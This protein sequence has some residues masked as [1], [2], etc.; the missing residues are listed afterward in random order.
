M[1][2]NRRLPHP[3]VLT[4]KLLI[5]FALLTTFGLIS[6]AGS[7]FAQGVGDLAVAP[8]RVVLE[9]RDRSAQIS[10]LNRGTVTATYR[11]SI[12]NMQMTE[13]GEYVRVETS[14]IDEGHADKLIRYAPR[15]V[16]LEP[17]K[18][19]TVRVLLRKPP[20]LPDGE[21]RSHI[22]FQ[23]VPSPDAG[24]SVEMATNN[25]GL[26]IRLIVVPGITIPLIVRQGNL[27]ANAS[28]AIG[29][30]STANGA[31]GGP[32]LSLQISRTGT[33]SL[34]GDIAAIYTAKNGKEYVVG[35]INQLA[36]YTP[37]RSRTINL[38][39]RIP[40]AVKLDGGQIRVE[41]RARPE[42][43]GETLASARIDVP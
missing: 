18:S 7:A 41:Y 15:Q 25:E 24:R 23:A 5:A 4:P 38:N 42:D 3:F 14:G 30:L 12:V 31:K 36:V 33:R 26:S 11:V 40:D 29:R 27:A 37:N 22:L 17:G 6:G 21:Y 35:E 20:N 2:M 9:G 13:A 34:F 1:R 43:G 8:T 39:L 28:L 16:V 32:T 19:Q 10:L